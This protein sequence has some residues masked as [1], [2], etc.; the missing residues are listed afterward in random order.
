[1]S[2]H[3]HDA[4]DLPACG[5]QKGKAQLDGNA[6]LFFLF[7]AVRVDPGQGFH[8]GRLPVIHVS[9][10]TDDDMLMISSFGGQSNRIGGDTQ[11]ETSAGRVLRMPGSTPP[12]RPV[13]LRPD[14]PSGCRDHRGR[15]GAPEP[16]VLF[17]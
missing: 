17:Y 14:G 13:S 10:R 6:A 12:A 1:M 15:S 7:E 4:Q 11:S 9:R 8:Q 3:V 16:G 5:F 2:R